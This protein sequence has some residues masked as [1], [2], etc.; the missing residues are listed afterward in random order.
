[1]VD[2]RDFLNRN[3]IRLGAGCGVAD[4]YS[5]LGLAICKAIVDA[6]NSSITAASNPNDQTTFT[7]RLPRASDEQIQTPATLTTA[8][9]VVPRNR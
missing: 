6:H 2:P 1:L 9:P 7:I 3:L 5:G 4:G 8:Q